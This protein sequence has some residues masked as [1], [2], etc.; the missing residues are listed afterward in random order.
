MIINSS[1]DSVATPALTEHCLIQL[2]HMLFHPVLPNESTVP[3]TN[4]KGRPRRSVPSGLDFH[5]PGVIIKAAAPNARALFTAARIGFVEKTCYEDLADAPEPSTFEQNS[6][7]LCP[8]TV[9]TTPNCAEHARLGGK[10]CRSCG[11]QETP[12][13]R[14]SWEPEWL[15]CNA[16]GLRYSKFRRRCLGCMYIPKKEERNLSRCPMCSGKWST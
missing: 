6:K 15:L 10:T 8:T 14:E 2:E 4:R 5:V 9:S 11:T 16:C 12:Y 3:K 1:N 13:W 7:L